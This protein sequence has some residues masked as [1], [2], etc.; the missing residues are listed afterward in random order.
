MSKGRHATFIFCLLVFSSLVRLL[1]LSV[2]VLALDCAQVS[3]LI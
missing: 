2:S 1:L 3:L